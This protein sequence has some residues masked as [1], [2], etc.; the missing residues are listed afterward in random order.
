MARAGL[1]APLLALTL[2]ACSGAQVDAKSCR[3]S[4]DCEAGEFCKRVEGWCDSRGRC[5]VRPEICTKIYAPVCG[6]DG[7]TYA[8]ACT[9][10]AVGVS[11]QD[12]G[13]CRR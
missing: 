12:A 8:S 1:A 3:S 6:C 11:I 9:A 5:E 7:E 10:A 13:P 4:A 2:A